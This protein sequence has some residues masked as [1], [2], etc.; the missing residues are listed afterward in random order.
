MFWQRHYANYVVNE[1]FTIITVGYG[2]IQS[3][4]CT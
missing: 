4:D 1:C 2:L 3:H